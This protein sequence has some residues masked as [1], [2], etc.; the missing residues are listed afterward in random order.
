MFGKSVKLFTLFGFEVK[1]DISWLIIVALISWT[2]AESFFPSFYE[3]LST[4]TYIIMGILG[5]LGLFISVI[6]HELSHSLVARRFDLP[7]EGI[8]LFIFGGVAEMEDEPPSAKAEFFM[9][10]AGPLASVVIGGICLGIHQLAVQTDASPIVRGVLRYV[11]L[12]NFVLAGFNIVPAFPLDGGRVLR[13]ILWAWKG[14]L[15]WATRV[16]SKF[17]S[18]F[19][20]A[21]IIL[22]II[23]M[24]GGN[25]IGGIWWM[26]IGLFLR[27]AS[28][29]SYKKILIRN[30]L[31]GE[32]VSRFMKREPVTVPP[33]ISVHEL[34]E[35]YIYQH[36]FK[37][38]PVVDGNN[39]LVGCV[40]TKDVK[41]VDREEW[42]EK[43][44]Q[45][46]SQT[47]SS[48]NTIHPDTDVVDALS[49]MH[50]STNSRLMVVDEH[51]KL[52]GIIALKDLMDFMNLKVDL[53]GEGD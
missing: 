15:G 14:K 8:T 4:Q 2:L 1:I 12:I 10:I 51:G 47:C 28:Q 41:N 11:W 50:K 20:L 5:A 22:G 9:A 24:F 34:V 17:G 32:P 16:A 13:S 36:H 3:D 45:D 31:E 6:L 49:T 35:D 53:E 44:V 23:N 18:G 33:N 42:D 26:L 7:I 52:R 37:M 19:G 27:N 39:E 40:T 46:L 30:N 21:L 48:N 25:I 29:M 43:T 38:F